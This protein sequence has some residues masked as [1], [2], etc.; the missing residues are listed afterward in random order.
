MVSVAICA[1]VFNIFRGD[2]GCDFSGVLRLQIA[3]IA[4][5]RLQVAAIAILRSGHLRRDIAKPLL[6]YPIP[7]DIF[8][9]VSEYYFA[10]ISARML[11]EFFFWCIQEP[12]KIRTPQE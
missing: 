7:H 5:L 11:E 4:V 12:F 6:R 2:L 10:M 1:L 3:A 9:I 8:L